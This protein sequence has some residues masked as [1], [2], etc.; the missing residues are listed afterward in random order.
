MDYKKFHL[1]RLKNELISNNKLSDSSSSHYKYL[2]VVQSAITDPEVYK[3]FRSNPG[4]KDILEHV[5][6]DLA[7]KYY[8]NIS[9]ELSH[10]E[11][12]D[13]CR[14]IKN[15]GNPR[16]ILI[17]GDS[18]NPTSLRYLNVALDIKSKFPN[19]SFD[20]IIEIGP[21]YGGQAIILDKFF[22]IKNYN[23]IDL[24]EVNLLI[25]KFVNSHSINFQAKFATIDSLEDYK[26]F[27]LVVSNYAFS[28]LPKKIQLIAVS[29]IINKSAKGYMIVNN[30]HKIS[31]RY[32]TQNKYSK[33]IKNLKVQEE[34]PNSYLFNKLLTFEA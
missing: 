1:K 14:A 23:F 20:N 17:K 27:D 9:N 32:M 25:E 3:T 10:K 4:Y 28:E 33:N 26:S 22:K 19:S 30:F 21:G 6:D 13:Y 31:F 29:K 8:K 15:I 16:L 34:I 2:D 24:P 11:I 7:N 18:F 12:L 5:G